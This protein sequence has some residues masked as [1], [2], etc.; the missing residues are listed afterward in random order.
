MVE[1]LFLGQVSCYR[2]ADL[3]APGFRL[4]PDV[5]ELL[6]LTHSSL[7]SLVLAV[8]KGQSEASRTYMSGSD[9]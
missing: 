1:R 6:K 4:H 2:V 5:S 3:R 8:G 7:K 9:D